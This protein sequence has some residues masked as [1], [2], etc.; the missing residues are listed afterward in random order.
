MCIVCELCTLLL[1]LLWISGHGNGSEGRMQTDVED[2]CEADA[3][4]EKTTKL[5]DILFS[6]PFPGT[7]LLFPRVSCT[8]K[9]TPIPATLL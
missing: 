1:N 3:E 8:G 4:T 2:Q 5:L 9:A 6:T 7:Q